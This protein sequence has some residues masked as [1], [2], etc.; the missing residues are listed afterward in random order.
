[1]SRRALALRVALIALA[2]AG[3][4]ACTNG[5]ERASEPPETTVPPTT[6][7]TTAPSPPPPFSTPQERFAL[8]DPPADELY[9]N[10]K[11][12]AGRVAQQLATFGP[13][14]SAGELARSVGA[15]GPEAAA[16][17]RTVAPLVDPAR[18]SSAEV[19]YVQISGVT[20]TTLGTMVLVRQHLEDAG[21]RRESVVRAMDVRLR[22]TDG[23][24]SL[25]RVASVGG[26]PVERPA[27]VS[28]AAARVLDNPNIELPDTA[29]WDIYR[30][31]IDD[32]LLRALAGAAD[33]WRLAISV[34]R[35]GHPRNVWATRRVSAHTVGLAADIYAVDGTPVVSQQADGSRAQQLVAS[36]LA[37]GATQVGSPW[38]LPPGGRR[39]FT[40]RVHRDHVHVQQTRIPAPRR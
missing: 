32:G 20:A 11:R 7:Q 19:V 34:L 2:A 26:T 15:V 25:D 5:G 18:R 35:S 21:G 39:S 33:R 10:G 40:D 38:A 6:A 8:Y 14:A 22:R 12:L 17:E 13:E 36:F 28:P 3:A 31:E 29:R 37:G 23:P 1:M 27:N 9:P 16:L 30:G 24:W 4:A